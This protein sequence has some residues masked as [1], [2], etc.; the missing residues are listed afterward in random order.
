MLHVESVEVITSRK[1]LHFSVVYLLLDTAV[2][3]KIEFSKAKK[4]RKEE[5]H[6]GNKVYK[7]KSYK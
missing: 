5:V 1:I 2:T 3:K 6:M 4:L 7:Q